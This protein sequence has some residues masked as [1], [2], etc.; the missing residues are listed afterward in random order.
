MK[1]IQFTDE[2]SNWI[3]EAINEKCSEEGVMNTSA[4][5]KL[6]KLTGK[7][8]TCNNIYIFTIEDITKIVNAFTGF[9]VTIDKVKKEVDSHRHIN[10]L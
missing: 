1:N 7:I 3:W 8:P 2:E 5:N 6:I 4:V 10:S 9:N